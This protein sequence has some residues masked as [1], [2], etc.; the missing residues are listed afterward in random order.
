M[1][2]YFMTITEIARSLGYRDPSHFS[3]SFTR[4]TGMSPKAY[5]DRLRNL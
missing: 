4:A 5:R 1:C 2:G 3:H